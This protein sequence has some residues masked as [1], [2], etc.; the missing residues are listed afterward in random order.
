MVQ[1]HLP[2]TEEI[3]T[4]I[5]TKLQDRGYT[6]PEAGAVLNF[7]RQKMAGKDITLDPV[8]HG[9]INAGDIDKVV[10]TLRHV[11]SKPAD[12]KNIVNTELSVRGPQRGRS[13]REEQV[14]TPVT[15]FLHEVVVDKKTYR[16][17]MSSQLN[18]TSQL[19]KAEQLY[20]ALK[21]Q[22]KSV[23]AITSEDKVVDKQE[24][25]KVYSAVYVRMLDELSQN[26]ASDRIAISEK[27]RQKKG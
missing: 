11:R 12:F 13:L 7:A 1:T 4:A 22:P 16:I 26:I 2:K 17:E 23:I 5:T 10:E 3:N 27:L 24:F 9:R 25:V 15:T 8:A 21:N 20:N 18:A 6:A 19:A 14:P